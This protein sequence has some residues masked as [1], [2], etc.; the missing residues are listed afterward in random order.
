[1][2]PNTRKRERTKEFLE[3]ALTRA[4]KLLNPRDYAVIFQAARASAGGQISAQ[5]RRE[6]MSAGERQLVDKAELSDMNK[7]ELQDLSRTVN[8][9]HIKATKACGDTDHVMTLVALL[10]A[11][12]KRR[13]MTDPIGP[14]YDE[15]D[16][17]PK[18][19]AGGPLPQPLPDLDEAVEMTAKGETIDAP[20]FTIEIEDD[21]EFEF[22]EPGD[23]I[24]VRTNGDVMGFSKHVLPDS[25]ED[26]DELLRHW[27]LIEKHTTQ[28]PFT[29]PA[30]ARLMFVCTAPNELELARKQA[31]VGEDALTFERLYLEPLGLTKREVAIGFAMPVVPHND[32]N[33]AMCEKWAHNLVDAMKSYGSAKVVALGRVAREVLSGAGVESFSLPHPSAVRKR[34][35]S[36]EVSRKLRTIAKSLDVDV[37]AVQDQGQR[38]TEPR[39]GHGSANLADAISEMRKTGHAVCRV[40]KSADEQQIVYGVV[41]DPYDVDLQTEWVPPAEIESSAHGFLKKSRVIGFEHI[42]RAEAQLVESWVEVYPSPDDYRAAKANQPHRAFT[43]KFGDDVIHSGTWVA[44]VQ[45]GDREWELHKQGKL[46]A[47]S[48]GGFS[49]KTKVTAAAMPEVE[50]IELIEAPA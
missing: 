38:K 35:N 16:G 31:M 3:N 1:M 2:P 22:A 24:D 42:E 49:F 12:Y 26:I 34:G 32:L 39:K 30:D 18:S 48:V 7:A 45:L 9:A 41:L 10:L 27:H 36:G 6:R 15:P 46:N 19:E 25:Q 28:V 11:E 14:A 43:R 23:I 20:L 29:G 47:F 40:I 33:A 13:G 50:F 21:D 4:Q 17:I 44:G 37:L 8:A 5:R